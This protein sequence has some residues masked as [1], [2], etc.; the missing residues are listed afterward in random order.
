MYIYI[1]IVIYTIYVRLS[2]GNKRFCKSQVF[3][4]FVENNH[5]I[6]IGS[7]QLQSQQSTMV[8]PL[9]TDRTDR[10]PNSGDHEMSRKP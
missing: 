7:C 2:A 6:L 10:I 3:A 4:S 9:R 8:I 5:K 1:G